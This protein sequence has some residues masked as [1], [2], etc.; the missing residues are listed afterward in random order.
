[1]NFWIK[2]TDGKPDAVLTLTIIGFFTCLIKVLASNVALELSGHSVNF[3]NVDGASIA[4][5]LTPTLGAYVAR[6]YTDRKY[7]PNAPDAGG[8]S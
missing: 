1:M 4:A 6:R 2:N 5:I 3:G 7:N 8:D